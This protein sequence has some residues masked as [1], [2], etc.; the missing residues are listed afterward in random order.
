[1]PTSNPKLNVVLIVPDYATE[2]FKNQSYS[3]WI[4]GHTDKSKI[5]EQVV[6]DLYEQF[7]Q[8]LENPRHADALEFFGWLE[9]EHGYTVF[10][11]TEDGWMELPMN[12]IDEADE[13]DDDETVVTELDWSSYED[14]ETLPDTC[15][16]C[17]LQIPTLDGGELA[18]KHHAESCSLYDP[19]KE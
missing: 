14:P 2:D 3:A 10:D 18:N 6:L 16:E 7:R 4:I 1:M 12:T 15:K 5:A 17:G 13:E 19:E 9:H 11:N 8:T